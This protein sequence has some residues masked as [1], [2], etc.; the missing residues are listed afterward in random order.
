LS[1]TCTWAIQIDGVSVTGLSAVSVS[2]VEQLVTALGANTVT[3]GQRVTIVS[4]SNSAA[5]DVE[6]TIMLE[7]L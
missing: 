1:G 5:L 6:F 3:T 2:S 7:V 4:S